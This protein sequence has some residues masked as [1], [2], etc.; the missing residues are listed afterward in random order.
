M[1]KHRQKFGRLPSE[2][3]SQLSEELGF[4]K[5]TKFQPNSFG[6]IPADPAVRKG[7]PTMPMNPPGWISL[8]REL[9]DDQWSELVAKHE[10]ADRLLLEVER[11]VRSVLGF[12]MAREYELARVKLAELHDVLTNAA[13]AQ[14]AIRDAE[15]SSEN[16]GEEPTPET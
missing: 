5:A 9:S 2:A 1:R 13:G 12:E 3:E 14:E 11:A 6:E 10:A 16:D 4:S 15:E 7:D 8:R